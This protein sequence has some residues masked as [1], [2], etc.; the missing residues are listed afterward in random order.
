MRPLQN[1][2][3][4]LT[5]EIEKKSSQS[6][7][8]IIILNAIFSRFFPYFFCMTTIALY[9]SYSNNRDNQTEWK[10]FRKTLCAL[11]HYLDIKMVL[12]LL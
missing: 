12:K 3:V 1:A 5:W 2:W 8:A 6:K 11:D 9:S 10:N 7:R 4:A